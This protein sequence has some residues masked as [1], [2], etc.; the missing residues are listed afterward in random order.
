MKDRKLLY[1]IYFITIFAASA[2]AAI[3]KTLAVFQDL[4]YDSGFFENSLYIDISNKIVIGAVVLAL[5]Y[6]LS[7]NKNSSLVFNFDSPL[8]YVFSGIASVALIFTAV[9]SFSTFLQIKEYIDKYNDV[10]YRDLSSEK[11]LMYILG[12]VAIFAALSVFHFIYSVVFLKRRNTKRADFGLIFVIF[13][14]L[15][16]SYLYFNQSTPLNAPI[17]LADQMAYLFTALFFLFETRISIGRERWRAYTAFGLAAMMLTAYSAIPAISVYIIKG[18]IISDSIYETVLTLTL[19]LFI[20]AR[21]LMLPSLSEDRENRTVCALRAMAKKR[22]EELT[23]E[24][25]APHEDG[26]SNAEEDRR[27]DYYE[28]NFGSDNTEVTENVNEENTGN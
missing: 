4:N 23:P 3:L 27:E 7:T 8:N 10:P 28:L 26:Q 13:L 16:T 2:A 25:I 9:N 14:S 11:V 22:E 1:G 20:T 17:K 15:Y 18:R 19:F 12:A 24:P 5:T 6:I 21:L